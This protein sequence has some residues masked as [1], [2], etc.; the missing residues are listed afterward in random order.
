MNATPQTDK[1]RQVS[2]ALTQKWRSQAINVWSR[3]PK[4]TEEVLVPVLEMKRRM[5]EEG[6]D[7]EPAGYF[8]FQEIIHRVYK[9]VGNLAKADEL[10]RDILRTATSL[11]GA[12]EWRN[13]VKVKF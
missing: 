6:L 1:L 4:L 12:Q 9:Q 2:K 5:E 7:V 11:L 3:D 13:G 8:T 10:G